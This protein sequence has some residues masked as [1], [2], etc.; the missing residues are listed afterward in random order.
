MT[1]EKRSVAA[2]QKYPY[3]H[4]TAVDAILDTVLAHLPKAKT[5]IE[6]YYDGQDEQYF[7]CK[8]CGGYDECDCSGYNQ[9]ILDIKDILILMS[10][11]AGD[12]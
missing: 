4:R 10:G 6:E 9:A 7:T 3:M 11:K 8:E 5:G 1:Y 2:Y 12:E